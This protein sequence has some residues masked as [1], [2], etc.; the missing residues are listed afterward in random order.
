MSFFNVDSTNVEAAIGL[1]L[2]AILLRR[3][4]NRDDTSR[5]S[6]IPEKFSLVDW[7]VKQVFEFHMMG[8]EN[9]NREE[10]MRYYGQEPDAYLSLSTPLSQVLVMAV[11][12]SACRIGYIDCVGRPIGQSF[13]VETLIHY[14]EREHQVMLA[15]AE[16]G[17]VA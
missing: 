10:V 13:T 6:K 5:S 15:E 9:L 14:L 3:W 11:I 12:K 8:P 17:L 16:E 4:A 1:I 7:V 2:V